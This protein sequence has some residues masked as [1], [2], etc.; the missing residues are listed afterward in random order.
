MFEGWKKDYATRLR[1]TKVILNK[2][3]SEDGSS[4]EKAKKKWWG[5]R[6]I[7]K[8]GKNEIAV[9]KMNELFVV[10]RLAAA[11]YSIYQ[12]FEISAQQWGL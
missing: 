3:G 11:S 5:R 2:L 7:K 4:I 9:G 12:K 8:E 10:I 1:E 6:N